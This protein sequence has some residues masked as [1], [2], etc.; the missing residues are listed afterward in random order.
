MLYHGNEEYKRYEECIEKYKS[1]YDVQEEDDYDET[2]IR[3]TYELKTQ[4][5]L[6]SKV[7][8]VD[9][10]DGRWLDDLQQSS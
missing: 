1:L 7:K 4:E 3:K 5:I 6:L 10:I 9:Y 2:F 8:K